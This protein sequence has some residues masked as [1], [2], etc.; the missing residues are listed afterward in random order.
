MQSLTSFFL[1]LSH[2]SYYADD[3]GTDEQ[4]RLAEVDCEIEIHWLE[5]NLDKTQLYTVLM[6]E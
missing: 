4:I 2:R 1:R 5:C 6:Q 3:L